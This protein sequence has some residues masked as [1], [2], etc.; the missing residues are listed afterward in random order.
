MNILIVE[1]DAPLSQNIQESLYMMGFHSY[2]VNNGLEALQLLR[3]TDYNFI[4]LDLMLPEMSGFRIIENIQDKKIPFVI[5]TGKYQLED[6]LRGF[7]LG[8]EDYLVKPFDLRELMAR[9]LVAL[10]RNGEREAVP[11][12][13]YRDITI[14]IEERLILRDG[15]PIDL[16]PTEFDLAVYFIQHQ[17]MLFSREKLLNVVWGFEVAGKT[18]TLDHHVSRLRKKLDWKQ[19]LVSVQYVGYKLLKEKL[20]GVK[21]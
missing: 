6:K 5:I 20:N 10:N 18:R 13:H 3:S 8:A 14:N 1:D 4:I 9:V 15:V 11:I 2:I 7:S 19:C 21:L 12:N 16:W 17:G